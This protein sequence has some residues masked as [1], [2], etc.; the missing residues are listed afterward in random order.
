MAS[1]KDRLSLSGP[2]WASKKG[3]R[4]VHFDLQPV[5][6]GKLL[7]LR[8]LRLEDFHDLY[9]VASDPLIWEQHPVQDR[10]KEDVFSRF[11]RESLESGGA[12]IAVDSKDGRVIGSSRFH[13]YDKEKNEIEIGWTFL[14]RSYWGGIYNPGNETAHAETCLQLRKQRCLPGRPTEFALTESRGKDRW[15]SCG[16]KARRWWPRQSCLPNHCFSLLRHLWGA[17]FTNMIRANAGR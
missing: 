17:G 9:A 16:I 14:A 6:K 11:F 2:L 7:E 10:Y 1:G 3:Q 15:N 12:L 13:G 4:R 8:P 5:L